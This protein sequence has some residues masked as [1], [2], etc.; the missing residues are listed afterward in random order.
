MFHSRIEYP[1]TNGE[2]DD[3]TGPEQEH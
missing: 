1:A 3:E 2:N